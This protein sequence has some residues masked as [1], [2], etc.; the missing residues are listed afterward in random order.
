[1]SVFSTVS[2]GKESKTTPLLGFDLCPRLYSLRDRHL[3]VPR[4][5]DVPAAIAHVAW[6]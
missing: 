1:M 5:L 6:C 3:H 4:G 2:L